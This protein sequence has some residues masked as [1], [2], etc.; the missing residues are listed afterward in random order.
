MSDRT[1]GWWGEVVGRVDGLVNELSK[2][3]S[4]RDRTSR[5]NNSV[6]E[7]A[8]L[9]GAE[10]EIAYRDNHYAAKL[11]DLPVED[12]TRK[13]FSVI[14]QG[15]GENAGAPFDEEFRRLDLVNA[16]GEA[17]RW[18]RLYG[19]AAVLLGVDDGKDMSEPLDVEAIMSGETIGARLDYVYVLDRYSLTPMTGRFQDDPK[20]PGH[21]LP[22]HYEIRPR[23]RV[24]ALGVT[25][26]EG[27]I[28]DGTIVHA[29][30]MIRF[31][32][33]KLPS[34]LASAQ[35]YWGDSVLQ[36][37][38]S[39]V[40]NL[41]NMDRAIGN[42]GQ[43]FIQSVFK[44]KGLRSLLKKKDAA[45]ALMDR[46][47]AMNLSQS[48]L[49]MIVIDDE[50]TFEKRTTNVSGLEQLHDR[51]SQSYASAADYPMTRILG[52]APG[53]LGTD[54]EAGARAIENA[55]RARQMRVYVPGLT[56]IAR[57][58]A[59]TV[60]GP[61]LPAGAELEIVPNALRELSEAD[62]AGALK[63]FAEA[64]SYLLDRN[65]L[66]REEVRAS[67][68]T[69][70][71]G[72]VQLDVSTGDDDGQV[73]DA[74]D[75]DGVTPPRDVQ[76]NA[77]RGL[78]LR[79]KYGRGGTRVG[80][81]RARDLANGRNVSRTTLERMRNFFNRHEANKHTPPSEGNGRI[82]WLLWGGDAG[83]R[84]AEAELKRLEARDVADAAT[85]ADPYSSWAEVNATLA[86]LANR[87]GWSEAARRGFIAAFNAALEGGADEGAAMAIGITA[88]REVA[89]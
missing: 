88:A 67:I 28:R 59:A 39:P 26:P 2:L 4:S 19:G 58:L 40:T 72:R 48:I 61:E 75:A 76:A 80:I 89:A 34:T 71:V 10:L 63:T 37:A 66:T 20:L 3:G 43:T 52:Q 22:S 5:I 6:E 38:Y 9:S 12:C 46:F 23:D 79:R 83:R 45:D 64:L 32:G 30:R 29:S 77:E 35:D 50:E 54:D 13:G 1:Q 18:A 11:I 25:A 60:E 44:M 53:G 21:G 27:A 73:F 36:R 51:I 74:R 24:R 87:E 82:A 78:R 62:R 41:T 68:R 85:R 33:V 55:T 81:A 31:W 70:E 65:V 49:S 17:D 69:G 15:G 86:A 56:F 16:F 84:W 57:V 8:E 7:V 14:V 42:I 47:L